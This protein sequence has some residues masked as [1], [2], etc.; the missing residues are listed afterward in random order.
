MILGMVESGEA[1]IRLKIRGLRGRTREIPAVIDT[2][3]TGS[4]TFPPILITA[5]RLR[6]HRTD[7]GL[8]ADGSERLFDV[9]E[10]KVLWDKKVVDVLVNETDAN[11][12]VGMALLDGFEL[13]VHVRD[14]GKV[15]IK[16]LRKSKS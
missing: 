14:R 11:P 3:F 9:Y 4:L 5:L 6:W 8:L 16:R 12:L 2:G 10:A 15:T 13:N 1:S 7:R